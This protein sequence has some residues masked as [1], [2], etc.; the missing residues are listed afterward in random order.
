[1]IFDPSRHPYLAAGS[2]D[3]RTVVKDAGLSGGYG[4]TASAHLARLTITG[5]SPLGHDADPEA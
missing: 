5:S 3:G 4:D 1:M 2:G